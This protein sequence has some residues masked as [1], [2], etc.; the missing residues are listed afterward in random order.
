MKSA[1]AFFRRN[2]SPEL[3]SAFLELPDEHKKHLM[4]VTGRRL[5][6]VWAFVVKQAG[7]AQGGF[8]MDKL[9][10]RYSMFGPRLAQA[11]V[12]PN[13]QGDVLVVITLEFLRLERPA[14]LPEVQT[15]IRDGGEAAPLDLANAELAKMEADHGK[16]PLWEL[17]C[18][19]CR[20]GA[21]DVFFEVDFGGSSKEMG[22]AV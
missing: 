10:Q 22:A 16:D 12:K 9:P 11:L 1:P 19:F 20:F 7:L 15:A 8:R 6:E 2:A 17:F 21:E 18:A 4:E 3:R 14:W 5:P 13:N